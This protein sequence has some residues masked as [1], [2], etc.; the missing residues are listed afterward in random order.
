MGLE[1][2]STSANWYGRWKVNGKRFCKNLGIPIGGPDGSP[3][4][5]KS[6]D[7]AAA[8]LERLR[9]ESVKTAHQEEL[10]Q[11]I[12]EIRTGH[13]IG[14][15]PL[16]QMAESW[17][18]IPRRRPP[19]ARYALQ[20]RAVLTRF[21][22]FIGRTQ[23]GVDQMAQVTHAMAKAFLDAESNRNVSAKTWNDTLQLLRATFK[24]LRRDAG[25]ADNPFEGIPGKES[26]TIFRKP[27]SPDELTAIVQSCQSDDFVRPIIVTGINTAMRLGDCCRLKWTDLDAGRQFVTVKTAKTGQTV[28]IPVF[29]PLAEELRRHQPGSSPYVF[30]AQADM[31]ITNPDGIT[32]RVRKAFADAG[33]RD[34][35]PRPGPGTENTPVPH[36]TP[37]RGD[38]RAER[39]KGEGVRKASIR[40]FHSFRVTWVTLALSNSVPLELVQKI[41]GHR[42]ADIVLKHY[43]QPGREQFRQALQT[44]LPSVLAGKVKPRDAQ[45]E[46]V[47]K[48]M[49]AKTLKRDKK[50]LLALLREP[51]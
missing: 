48:R 35:D 47:I 31:Y 2:R 18:R 22:E 8:E 36:A 45:M 24:H 4:F 15:V 7:K 51:S 42:T 40:D 6:R 41:T 3:S 38:I 12:H 11:T 10:V 1:R 5:T 14:S 33:F 34:P 9:A 21:V 50:R 19:N 28:S 13:R 32:K 30:P 43:F 26:K 17:Q 16:D 23:T 49:S 46:S 29:P 25:L 20:C 39:A 27:F 44:R 37:R